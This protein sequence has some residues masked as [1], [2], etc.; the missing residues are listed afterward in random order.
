[1]SLSSVHSLEPRVC[2]DPRAHC[3]EHPKAFTLPSA[4]PGWPRWEGALVR[5]QRGMRATVIST[6]FSGVGRA[7]V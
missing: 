2:Q 1:M 5:K 3:R 7:W 4:S 6:E